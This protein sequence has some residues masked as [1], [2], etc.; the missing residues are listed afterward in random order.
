MGCQ[1]R[2]NSCRLNGEDCDTDSLCSPEYRGE[3][4]VPHNEEMVRVGNAIMPKSLVKEI[5][6]DPQFKEWQNGH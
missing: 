4:K 2:I 1:Y 6:N 5:L 3:T